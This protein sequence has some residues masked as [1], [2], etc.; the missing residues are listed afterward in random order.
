MD[1]PPPSNEPESKRQ[2]VEGEEQVLYNCCL[3]VEECYMLSGELDVTS[4]RQKQ[5][6]V[7]HP[8]LFLAPKLRDCEVSLARL[9]PEHR[10]LFDRAKTK[11]VNSFISNA[12]VRRC[13]DLGEENEARNSG[14]LMRC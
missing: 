2:R 3:E 7:K 11:E 14:K 12:A 1:K 13:L 9:K 4:Q 10:K 6:F 8:S 5:Q